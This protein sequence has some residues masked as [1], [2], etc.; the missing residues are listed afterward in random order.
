MRHGAS[1]FPAAALTLFALIVPAAAQEPMPMPVP[2][3]AP[4]L[5][6]HWD[7]PGGL[8]TQAGALIV[9]G[10]GSPGTASPAGTV[11]EVTVFGSRLVRLNP[12]TLLDAVVGTPATWTV[13]DLGS[14]TLA[15]GLVIDANDLV[16]V[17]TTNDLQRIDP[18]ANLR[19]S[20]ADGGG[21]SQ[22]AVDAGGGVYS[23]T[24][25]DQIERLT[26]AG[27]TD[28]A[29]TT[30]PVGSTLGSIMGVAVDPASGL[31][32]FSDSVANEIGE[33]DPSSG[34][35]RRWSVP[36]GVAQPRELEVDALGEVWA[37]TGSNHL[38]RLTVPV[39][40]VSVFT[41]P[42]PFSV[43][44]GIASDA[45]GIIAFTES[46]ANKVGFLLPIGLAATVAPSVTAA[47]PASSMLAGTASAQLPLTGTSIPVTVFDSAGATLIPPPSVEIT[48][49]SA[50]IEVKLPFIEATTPFAS[51]APWG[52]DDDAIFPVGTFY[53]S[54]S[55]GSTENR[56][57]RIIP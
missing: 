16:F 8:G 51:V 21:F 37:V 52:I 38:V 36:E 5:L 19:T 41:I 45:L 46:Q 13:W 10:T 2:L 42:T 27:A 22:I 39:N 31:V 7:L 12:G 17:R 9:D 3:P 35:V 30:W 56:V 57:A 34:V 28:A 53:F 1:G 15:S 24:F 11:W 40:Q 54:S 4:S 25:G 29:V 33:L 32:Y 48:L 26:P 6:T 14:P 23:A 44:R 18:A 49:P 20:W 50:S 47:L 55:G 43:P